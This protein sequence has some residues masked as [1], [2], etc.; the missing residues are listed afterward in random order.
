LSV[1]GRKGHARDNSIIRELTGRQDRIPSELR[2]VVAAIAI[3][4]TS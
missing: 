3:G 4:G 2:D 1:G